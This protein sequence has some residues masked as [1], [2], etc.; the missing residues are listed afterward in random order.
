MIEICANGLQS[1]LNAQ[2]GGAERVELCDNLYAGGTTPSAGTIR[3]ARKY[4]S[5]GLH[6]LIRPRGG[7]FLYNAHE[8]EIMKDDIRFCKDV[9]ADGVV[10]GILNADG[11]ID[12]GR[13][14]ELIELARPMYVTFHRAF[15]MCLDAYEA[16]EQL[17][18]LNVDCLL[19]AGQKNKASDGV[20]LIAQ[21]VEQAAGRIQIMPGS[22]VNADNLQ[23]LKTRT[24]ATAFHMT[25]QSLVNSDMTY[26]NKD[27][28]MGALP[29]IPEYKYAV[30]DLE[31][32]R[33][34]VSKD[35]EMTKEE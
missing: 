6:V 13:T 16:L 3:L 20:E 24:G 10:I 31:K 29:Q 28:R 32:I 17:I 21:L 8:M 11:S 14:A 22:G 35:Q 18:Q 30:S 9:G 2:M 23:W 5:I 27:V 25:A 1:A 15:D 12:T 19:T 34:I 4:L 33:L 7:D 26:R